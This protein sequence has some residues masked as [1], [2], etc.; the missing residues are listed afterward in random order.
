[1]EA[2]GVDVAD[3]FEEYAGVPLRLIMGLVKDKDD[4]GGGMS[5]SATLFDGV[6]VYKPDF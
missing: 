3:M 6:A 1:M 5:A 2:A 4:V